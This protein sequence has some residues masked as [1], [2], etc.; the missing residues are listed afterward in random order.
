MEAQKGLK[1]LKHIACCLCTPNL[2]SIWDCDCRRRHCNPA[3]LMCGYEATQN[4]RDEASYLRTASRS[5]CRLLA[6]SLPAPGSDTM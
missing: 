4:E 6:F 3:L 1:F 2:V 5:L